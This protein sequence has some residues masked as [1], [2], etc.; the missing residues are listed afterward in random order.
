MC[1]LLPE[2]GI[3]PRSEEELT[4][5]RLARSKGCKQTQEIHVWLQCFA[6]YV[7]VIAVKCPAQ[8]PELMAYMI[9]IIRASQEYEVLAQFTYNEA[10]R[11]QAAVTQHKEWSKINPLIFS[12]C[13]TRRAR[14]GQRCESCLS[15]SNGSGYWGGESDMPQD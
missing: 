4:S 11:R 13:F 12:V 6:L 15:A 2:L 7:A 3:T 9:Q 5:Q 8:V 14:R 10:Y 1:H